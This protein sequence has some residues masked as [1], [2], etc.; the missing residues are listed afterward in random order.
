LV[1]WLKLVYVVDSVVVYGGFRLK[2]WLTVDVWL[3]GF[4]EKD[5]NVFFLLFFFLLFYSIFSSNFTLIF[6]ARFLSIN[7]G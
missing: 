4:K 6:S 1:G 7:G 5:L 3:L 2:R